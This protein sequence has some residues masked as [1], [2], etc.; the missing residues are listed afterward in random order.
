MLRCV[1]LSGMSSRGLSYHLEY[2]L[3]MNV[4]QE[5]LNSDDYHRPLLILTVLF[6]SFYT[7]ISSIFVETFFHYLALCS[8]YYDF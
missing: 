7:D 5:G 1:F 4:Y 6:S 3:H 8:G 2:R